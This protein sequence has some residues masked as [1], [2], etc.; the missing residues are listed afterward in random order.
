ML[1]N[2]YISKNLENYTNAEIDDGIARENVLRSEIVDIG[3]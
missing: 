3:E 2:R 1:F